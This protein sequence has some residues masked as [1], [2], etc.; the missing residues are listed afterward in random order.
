AA[1]PRPRAAPR[2]RAS[3][4]PQPRA[5]RTSWR[6]VEAMA[7]LAHR[8]RDAR[9]GPPKQLARKEQEPPRP[10]RA[11]H[12][13]LGAPSIARWHG[14]VREDGDERSEER[15]V[16]KECRARRGAEEQRKS[17]KVRET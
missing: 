15:R 8:F 1:H 3:R 16:G 14:A 2:R 5:G 9:S 12:P 10:H 4:Q 6:G 11:D 7:E 17:S 13:P